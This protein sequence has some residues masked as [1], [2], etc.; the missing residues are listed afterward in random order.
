MMVDGNAVVREFK[1]TVKTPLKKLVYQ[2]TIHPSNT[3][4]LQYGKEK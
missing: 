1:F 3:H 4:R 2:L